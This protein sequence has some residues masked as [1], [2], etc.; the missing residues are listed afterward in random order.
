MEHCSVSLDFVEQRAD[1][2]VW[3]GRVQAIF[4]R[5]DHAGIAAANTQR[6]EKIGMILRVR[7]E[8]VP[9]DLR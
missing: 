7:P 9:P 1:K 3:S 4:E 2:Y 8:L 5:R 6:L